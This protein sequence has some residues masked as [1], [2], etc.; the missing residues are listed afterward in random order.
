MFHSRTKLPLVLLAAGLLMKS[1]QTPGFRIAGQVVQHLSNR[2]VKGARVSISPLTSRDRPISCISGENGEFYFSGLAA[3]KYSLA[4]TAHGGVQLY[5]Q[6][7]QYS[8]AIAVGPGIDSEHIIFPLRSQASISGTVVDD[9]GDPVSG[10]T[11]HLFVQ[12]IENGLR[13]TIARS[14]VL[15]STD[16]SFRFA[17]LAPG[18]YYVAVNGRPW[19]AQLNALNIMTLPNQPA[20]PPAP[21]ELDVAYPVTYYGNTTSPDAATPV[22]LEEGTHSQI[23]IMLQPVPA[24][25]IA[26]NGI[27]KSPEQQVQATVFQRGPGGAPISIQSWTNNSVLTGIAPGDYIL[28]TILVGPGQ[29]PGPIGS[30]A[31]TLSGNTTIDVNEAAETSLSGKVIS[32]S[33]IPNQVAV[34]LVDVS[35]G[36]QVAAF[37]GPD[38][39]LRAFGTLAAGTYDVRLANTNEFYIQSVTVKGGEYSKGR[40]TVT[41]GA[42]IDLTITVA[43]GLTQVNGIVL[44]D[45]K[46]VAGAMVLAFPQDFRHGNYIP[47]DQSDSDGTFTLNFVAPG[48]YTLVAIENGDDLEY[49]NAA[50][51]APYLKA[52]RVIEAPLAK[53]AR[54]EVEVQPRINAKGAPQ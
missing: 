40:L 16:G 38:G 24:V 28:S 14:T 39:S 19:Y 48:P 15:T 54:V 2:P 22:K 30:Q 10:A 42:H 32:D 11:V 26:L 49:A 53:D 36:N 17:H 34:A 52:G 12:S 29:P 41:A 44:R 3:G 7:G 1:Q 25:H 45:K 5:G 51:I 27:E 35:N 31:V 13:Q 33:D 4:V 46:P 47:R 50:V 23:Q 9:A 18:T 20:P 6:M 43:R 8:T 37:L 21:A